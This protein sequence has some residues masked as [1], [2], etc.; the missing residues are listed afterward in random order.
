[1]KQRPSSFAPPRDSEIVLQ[2]S[3]ALAD[4][5]SH[6]PAFRD[7]RTDPPES[8]E[9]EGFDGVLDVSLVSGGHLYLCIEA[10]NSGEP[11]FL[12][13]GVLSL[14]ARIEQAINRGKGVF[15]GILAA[16]Y[17]S[18][19]GAEICEEAGVGYIDLAGNC[20]V[21]H[22]AVYVRIE[23]RPN[24]FATS[25]GMK[26]VFERSSVKS[27]VVLRHFFEHPGRVWKIDQMVEASGVSLGQVSKVK[28]FLEDREWIE[29]TKAGFRLTDSAGV[30]AE[31][32]ATYNRKPNDGMDF[33]ALDPIPE[34]EA[35]LSEAF[36]RKHIKG[37]LTG[38]SGGVR[39]VP[40][41]RYQRVHAYVDR[42][43]FED[44]PAS[45]GWKRVSS[46]ANVSLFVP[47]DSCV[48]IGVREVGNGVVVSPVQAYLDLM[49][50]KG[51][52]E[53]AAQAVLEGAIGKK[54]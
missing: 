38:F 25:R 45:F 39:Y 31:W 35:K 27:G 14:A 29:S 41:V 8:C 15:Y 26:S 30:L 47:Y 44:L 10:K 9:R 4:V 43:H 48:L 23:G 53:E 1:M 51:R 54:W 5:L 3:K 52:G 21:R 42:G 2:A 50:L 24:P 19:S 28:R 12:R 18:K 22:E 20:L 33:Y 17:I 16:P 34:I 7:I 37:A 46:G 11:R 40:A 32:S 36:R 6:L 49:G 13:T